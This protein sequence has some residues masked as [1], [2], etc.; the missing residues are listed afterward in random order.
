MSEAVTVPTLMMMTLIVSEES[1]VRDR[2]T[3]TDIQ[4]DLSK[5]FKVAYD[6][7]TQIRGVRQ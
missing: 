3:H 2:H 7:E 5:I 1:L 6:F 4:V